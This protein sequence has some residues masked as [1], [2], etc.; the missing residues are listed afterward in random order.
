MIRRMYHQ[1]C[2]VTRA[3][4][5]LGQQQ[6][7][8]H[9]VQRRPHPFRPYFSLLRLQFTQRLRPFLDQR[10]QLVQLHSPHPHFPLRNLLP[11]GRRAF[12]QSHPPR[13]HSVFVHSP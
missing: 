10:V 4:P 5:H 12:S 6:Q 8:V 7:L 2:H 9:Q 13:Q 1:A 3:R 11:E